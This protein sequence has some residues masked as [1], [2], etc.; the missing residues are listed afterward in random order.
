DSETEADLQNGEALLNQIGS[1]IPTAS[2]PSPALLTAAR[3]DLISTLAGQ[4]GRQ[5]NKVFRRK[6]TQ[7]RIQAITS[8]LYRF[9]KLTSSMAEA[10]S[11]A[12]LKA[13]SKTLASNDFRY[14][15]AA[16]HHVSLPEGDDI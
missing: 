2:K 11:E 14:L 3:V 16:C 10:K 8:R 7:E 5:A 1:H 4:I 12:Y 6:T 9:P 13:I 15:S